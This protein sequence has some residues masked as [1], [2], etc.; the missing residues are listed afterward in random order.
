MRRAA[1]AVLALGLSAAPG[2]TTAAAPRDFPLTPQT[3]EIG[4]RAY[5][6]GIVPV[7]GTFRRFTGT[8]TIDRADPDTCTVTV[9]V[10]TT[11]LSMRDKALEADTLSPSLLDA[12][13][14]PSFSYAGQCQGP[15]I[16]GL[17]TLHGVT[18]PLF[19]QVERNGTGYAAQSALR[20]REW[21]ITG[22]PLLAGPTIRIRVSTTLPLP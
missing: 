13:A 3:A 19:L 16:A 8:L 15:G 18:K 9:T 7:D 14:F 12:A 6:F 4:F 2:A 21:G 10:D 11:S 20:R 5:A 1:A 17:L 22:R